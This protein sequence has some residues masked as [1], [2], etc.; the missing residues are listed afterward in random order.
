MASRG[1]QRVESLHLV[2][3]RGIDVDLQDEVS[4]QAVHEIDYTHQGN[5][6][7]WTRKE[8]GMEQNAEQRRFI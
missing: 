6:Y 4:W 1:G 7:I 5:V 3:S 8:S 2:Q